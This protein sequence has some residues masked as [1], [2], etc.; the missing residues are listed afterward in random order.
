MKQSPF[1]ADTSSLEL[2]ESDCWQ[3]LVRSA[4][5]AKSDFRLPVLG[6]QTPTNAAQRIVVL[7]AADAAA[8][9]LL[10]HTD[11]RSAKVQQLKDNPVAALLFYDKA[12]KVQL[13]VT[14]VA[15]VHTDDEIANQL[16]QSESATSLKG[17]LGQLAPGTACAE[18]E[19]NLPTEFIESIPDRSQL[20]AARPNFAAI[21][22]QATQLDWLQLNR[23]GHLQ[24][25]FNYAEDRTVSRTWTAP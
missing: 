4:V 6:T 13:R 2:I 18:R 19:H 7:R 8:G 20:E 14:A 3:L 9:T 16:W 23:S 12:K 1:F 22:F 15:S 5:D 25:Q 21:S 17:Y 24:A 11:V 10:I